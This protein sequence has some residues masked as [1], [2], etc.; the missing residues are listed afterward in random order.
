MA[1]VLW[2][3]VQNR[4]PVLSQLKATAA[5]VEALEPEIQKLNNASFRD[6]INECRDLARLNRLK[7]KHLDRALAIAREACLRSVGMRPFPVQIMGA[8]AMINGTIAEMATGEGKKRHCRCLLL[9]LL[10]LEGPCPCTSLP[11]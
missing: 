6:A 8:A 10:A 11:S 3:W 2:G 5:R 7:G 4:R 1:N 9:E